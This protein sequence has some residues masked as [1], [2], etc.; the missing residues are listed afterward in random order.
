MLAQ[1]RDMLAAKD[2]SVVAKENNNCGLMLPERA[3]LHF[4][5]AR[6]RQYDRRKSLGNSRRHMRFVP[7]C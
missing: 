4:A 1:L 7:R 5:A 3:Q 6:I 2:S